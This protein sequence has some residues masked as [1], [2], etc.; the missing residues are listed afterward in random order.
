MEESLKIHIKFALLSVTRPQQQ[1]FLFVRRS[2]SNPSLMFRLAT[3]SF[4]SIGMSP[5]AVKF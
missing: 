2:M 4:V 5:Y 3:V 1:N